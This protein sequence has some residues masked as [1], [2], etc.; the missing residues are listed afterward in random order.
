V[1]GRKRAF[2][3]PRDGDILGFL[4]EG[5]TLTGDL[6]LRGGFRVDGRVVGR[7]TSP[8]ALIVGPSGVIEAEELHVS[9]LSVSG[10]VRG[11]LEV[12]DRLEVHAGGKVYGRVRLAKPGLVVAPGGL[13][14]ATLEMEQRESGDHVQSEALKGSEIPGLAGVFHQ[15]V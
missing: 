11:N 5:N 12:E 10:T 1:L 4:A 15:D 13:L 8:A 6:T 3:A 7:I 2:D 14:E 9:T